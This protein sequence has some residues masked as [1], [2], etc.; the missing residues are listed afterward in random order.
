MFKIPWW[1][2]TRMNPRYFHH[3]R[4]RN[5]Q[6]FDLLK[7]SS[8]FETAVFNGTSPTSLARKQATKKMQASWRNL[9]PGIP[10]KQQT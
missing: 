4:N 3:M 7:S 6:E 5:T 2:K 9:C 8:L 10:R 1:I